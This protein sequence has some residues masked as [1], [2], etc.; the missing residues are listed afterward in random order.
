MSG[1]DLT[2]GRGKVKGASGRVGNGY[3]VGNAF[4]EMQGGQR[5]RECV[6]CELAQDGARGFGF[7]KGCS[8]VVL[9]T[10]DGCR[11]VRIGRIGVGTV[12]VVT[13]VPTPNSLSSLFVMN[14]IKERLQVS[15]SETSEMSKKVEMQHTSPKIQSGPIWLKS[16]TIPG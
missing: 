7:G 10:Q 15:R 3:S 8:G 5:V 16:T 6:R 1:I 4:V 2:R 13:A 11:Q 9:T 12:T 14:T